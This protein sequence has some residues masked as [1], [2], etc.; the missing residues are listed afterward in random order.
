VQGW[1]ARAL[2]LSRTRFF[3]RG[4]EASFCFT[5]RN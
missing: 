2:G 5:K 3:P 4:I 1:H